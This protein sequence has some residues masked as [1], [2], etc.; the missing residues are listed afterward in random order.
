[1]RIVVF[2]ATSFAV[3]LLYQFGLGYLIEHFAIVQQR[4]IWL[5]VVLL[6]PLSLSIGLSFLFG[7][8][9][10][11]IGVGTTIFVVLWGIVISPL[12]WVSMIYVACVALRRCL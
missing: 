3:A 10:T 1:M 7:L 5:V 4:L 6:G 8:W 2:A 9:R 11:N 12:S